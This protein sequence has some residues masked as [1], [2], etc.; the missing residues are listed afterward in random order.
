MPQVIYKTGCWGCLKSLEDPNEK[1]ICSRLEQHLK[2]YEN[3]EKCLK[4]KELIKVSELMFKKNK[5]Y[6]KFCYYKI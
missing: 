6:C 1:Y 5:S 4:C 2:E 3:M